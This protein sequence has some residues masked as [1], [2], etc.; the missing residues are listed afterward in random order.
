MAEVVAKG[1]GLHEVLIQKERLGDRPRYLGYLQGMGEARP[2]VIIAGK[3][4][5]WVLYLSLRKDLLCTILS[6][7]CWNAGLMSHATSCL[8]RPLVSRLF[9]ANGEKIF[10]LPVL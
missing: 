10:T 2:V 3:K 6:R 7:S 1:D 4:N 9:C 8:A 5:T